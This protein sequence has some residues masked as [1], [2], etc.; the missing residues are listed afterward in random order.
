MVRNYCNLTKTLGGG[1]GTAFPS[2]Y[3]DEA[4]KGAEWY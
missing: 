1:E 2:L 3:Y 4:M